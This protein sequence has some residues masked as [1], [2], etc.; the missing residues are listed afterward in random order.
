VEQAGGDLDQFDLNWENAADF[1]FR[2]QESELT[3]G[4]LDVTD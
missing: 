2:M 4:D 3:L 1:E